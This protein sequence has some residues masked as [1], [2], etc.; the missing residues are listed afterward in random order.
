MQDDAAQLFERMTDLSTT[1]VCPAFFVFYSRYYETVILF[2]NPWHQQGGAGGPPDPKKF[3]IV[4]L[5]TRQ[6]QNR[7]HIDE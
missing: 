6:R 4:S 1:L 3:R 2:W 7:L 5:M